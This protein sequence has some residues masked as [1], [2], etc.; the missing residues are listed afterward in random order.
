MSVIFL[1][2][3]CKLYPNHILSR[4]K[5]APEHAVPDKRLEPTVTVNK[6]SHSG[7]EFFNC[8]FIF[9][10]RAFLY[11]Y[12]LDVTHDKTEP[13]GSVPHEKPAGQFPPSN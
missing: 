9:E 4:K 7:P 5:S 12:T 3:L 10:L 2:T 11:L 13:A 6:N 1:V 8:T